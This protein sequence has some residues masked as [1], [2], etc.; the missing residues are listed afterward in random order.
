MGSSG[1]ERGKRRAV[2]GGKGVGEGQWW[3]GKGYVKGISGR[4]RVGRR[5]A[6]GLLIIF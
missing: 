1:R 3:Q 6:V 2:V 4:E 5:A